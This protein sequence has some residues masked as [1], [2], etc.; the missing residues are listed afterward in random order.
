MRARNV[1]GVEYVDDVADE[2]AEAQL[3]VDMTRPPVSA[4]VEAQHR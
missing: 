2:I 3:V 1:G 4:E